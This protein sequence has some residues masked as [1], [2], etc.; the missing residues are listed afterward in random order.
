MTKTNSE[1]DTS[2]NW[3]KAQTATNTSTNLVHCCSTCFLVITTQLLYGDR[4]KIVSIRQLF[5]FFLGG[6]GGGG[7]VLLIPSHHFWVL[8]TFDRKYL[9]KV[10]NGGLKNHL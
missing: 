6:G 3:T 4:Q 7:G 1:S 2:C 9:V 10:K 8:Q 5:F